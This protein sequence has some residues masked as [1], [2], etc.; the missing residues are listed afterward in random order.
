MAAAKRQL[1]QRGRGDVVAD[2]VR[3][4]CTFLSEAKVVLRSGGLI[5]TRGI[6]DVV[7]PCVL[8]VSGQAFRK[9]P[10]PADLQGV[11][12]IRSETGLYIQFAKLISKLTGD[13]GG[14]IG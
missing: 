3:I 12:V 13:G 1:V 6:P 14:P 2:V 5:G 4:V 8:Q 7:A 10:V 9:P 11:I